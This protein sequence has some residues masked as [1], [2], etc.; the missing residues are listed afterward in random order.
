SAP[1]VGATWR[2]SRGPASEA[3]EALSLVAAG[4]AAFML[5]R[6]PGAA[7]RFRLI[8]GTGWGRLVAAVAGGWAVYDH[9]STGVQAPWGIPDDI[10]HL[11]AMTLWIGGL[12]MLAGV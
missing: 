5:P 1:R 12:A 6:L 8:A 3:R 9:A 7:P 2:S 11:D 10:V 4:V